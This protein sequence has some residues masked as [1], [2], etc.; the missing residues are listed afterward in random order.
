MLSTGGVERAA[1]DARGAAGPRGVRAGHDRS[2]EGAAHHPQPHPALRVPPAAGRRA[3][4][5]TSAGSSTDAGLDVADEAV[6]HVVRRAAG[7]A[8]DTLS[9]LDQVAGGGR[10]RRRRRAARRA[11]RGAADA[12]PARPRRRGQRRA[13]PG[14]DPRVLGRGASGPLRDV[15]LS[16]MGADRSRLPDRGT[17]AASPTGPSGSGDRPTTRALEVL[18]EALVEMRQAP[19]PRIPLEVALVRLTQPDADAS[20]DAPAGPRRATRAG[21]R[22]RRRRPQPTRARRRRRSTATAVDAAA[23][24][25]R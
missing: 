8:R 6:D 1:E 18:G 25:R 22:P 16:R 7:S 5:T 2:A 9:A 10:R 4:P 12:T 23:A 17:P 13:R 24:P 21:R 3:R 14:R 19:D 11:R 15:F 20:L